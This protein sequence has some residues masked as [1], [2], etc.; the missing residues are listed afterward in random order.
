MEGAEVWLTSPNAAPIPE[1]V[2]G[3]RM[4]RWC[5]GAPLSAGEENLPPQELEGDTNSRGLTLSRRLMISSRLMISAI[6]RI[7]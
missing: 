7:I 3:H 1:V 4:Q 2:R 6:I 5:Q